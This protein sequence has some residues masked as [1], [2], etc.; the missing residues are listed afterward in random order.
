MLHRKNQGMAL[1][2]TNHAQT[3]GDCEQRLITL[4]EKRNTAM[5]KGRKF[6]KSLF[7]KSRPGSTREGGSLETPRRMLMLQ[8]IDWAAIGGPL[9]R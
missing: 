5:K 3:P 1:G 6:E 4:N 7:T 8:A 2:I 9:I